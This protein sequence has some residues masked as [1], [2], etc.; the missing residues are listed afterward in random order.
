MRMYHTKFHFL[1]VALLLCACTD[2]DDAVTFETITTNKTVNL[3]NDSVPPTCNVN[4]CLEQAT[5]KSGRAGEIIN[6]TVTRRLFNR[7]DDKM[8]KA[9]EAFADEYTTNYVKTLLPLYNQDR[10]DSTKRTWYH[11]H[12]II[13]SR[14][15]K[16]N[17]GTLVYIADINYQEGGT[18][19]MNHQIVWNFE[20]KTG[21]QIQI[22]DIFIDGF[23]AQLKPILLN[24]LKENTGLTTMSA[25]KEKGYLRSTNIYVPENF[26]LGD[27]TITFVYNPDEI[28]PNSLGSIE[29]TI[30][31]TEIENLLVLSFKH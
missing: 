13:N 1:A 25:L 29:L 16:G 2:N 28:A 23:E 18:Q 12:Y 15:Q 22:K 9:A 11:Y 24:A 31:Y 21:R 3:S 26:I 17:E 8:Q 4:I 27:E 30:S 5:E 20:E 14:T 7:D 6:S 10:N 19:A